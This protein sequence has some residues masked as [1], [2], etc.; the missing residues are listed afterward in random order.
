MSN[1][2]FGGI[3]QKLLRALW[4]ER[5]S[6]IVPAGDSALVV[7]FEER[8]DPAVNA[9]AI[10]AGRG[11]SGGACRRRPRRGADLP[12]GRDLL[13]SAA[14]RLATRCWRA[15]SARRRSRR[16]TGDRG[17]PPVRIPVCYGGE[18]GPDLAARCRVRAT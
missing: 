18:L 6:A 10:A 13:R 7:E 2:G 3:H 16:P 15:S 11:G 14:H 17:R 1:G 9:R 8:I 5:P 4:R 12:I